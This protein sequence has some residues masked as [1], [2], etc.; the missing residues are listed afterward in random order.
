M[1]AFRK[2]VSNQGSLGSD[3]EK[4][5]YGS[6]TESI[7]PI[8]GSKFF[9]WKNLHSLHYVLVRVKSSPSPAVIPETNG[10]KEVKFVKSVKDYRFKDERL[11]MVTA[12]H[13]PFFVCSFIPYTRSH[14]SR[15]IFN[16]YTFV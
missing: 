4:H 2:R 14:R 10:K 8:G 5:L 3:T 15:L 11:V 6:S 1:P 12:R 7:G 13:T 16:D 9:L